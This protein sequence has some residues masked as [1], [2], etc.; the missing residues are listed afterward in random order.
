MAQ[1]DSLRQ[2][3]VLSHGL[4]A[5]HRLHLGWRRRDTVKEPACPS[6][7]F[8]APFGSGKLLRGK[9]GARG[10]PEEHPPAWMDGKKGTSAEEFVARVLRGH[11]YWR[12]F[13]AVGACKGGR[14]DGSR[15]SPAT[16]GSCAWSG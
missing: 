15:G 7:R 13:A 10:R 1:A 8:C 2:S 4:V 3:S 9:D 14:P 6:H 16:A 11:L 12:G 5:V